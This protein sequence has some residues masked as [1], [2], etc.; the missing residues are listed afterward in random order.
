MKNRIFLPSV[1]LVSLI[2][3][4]SCSENKTDQ[5]K[6]ETD[7][8]QDSSDFQYLTEQFA[9]LKIIRYQIPGW[10]ELSLN[11]KKLAYYLTRAAYAGRDISWIRTTGITLRFEIFLKKYTEP[12][13]A[14]KQVRTEGI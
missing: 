9:D 7:V 10:D 4:G 12:T 3:F 14:I 8:E 1:V 6:N 11:D 13:P 2:F 5:T